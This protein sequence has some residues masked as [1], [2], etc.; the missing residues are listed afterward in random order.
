MTNLIRAVLVLAAATAGLF[1]TVAV[2]QAEPSGDWQYTESNETCRAFREFGSG[3]NRTVLQL[4]SYG[5]GSAIELTVANAALPQEPWS[6]REV[7]WG[8]DGRNNERSQI[9]LVGATS[10]MP[11]VT[12]LTQTRYGFVFAYGDQYYGLGS[13]LNLSAETL[14]LRVVGDAPL[15]L[16]MG[17]LEEPVRHMMDCELRLMERWGWG[18]DYAARVARP[19]E[20]IETQQMFYKIII[21]PATQHLTR[22]SSLLELRL[23]L[24]D[25]G[26]VTDCF[27]QSSPGSGLFGSKNCENFRK[28][29]RFKPAED[30]EGR[31]IPSQVQLSI[32]FAMFD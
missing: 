13:P 6:V 8:W 14:Q 31:P 27:V 4:R 9:G 10:G 20:L 21:Y 29:G 22:V 12:L 24:D 26:K 25:E 32:T 28:R 23:K 30:A 1:S 7:E 15:A 2:A 19:P 3:A 18:P 16:R 5:P 17:P 11:S